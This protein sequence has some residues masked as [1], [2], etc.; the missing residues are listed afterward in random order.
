MDKKSIPQVVC[1]F[2]IRKDLNG[3]FV[4]FFHTKGVLTFNELGAF[5]VEKI[6]G[7]TN[8]SE[9]AKVVSRRYPDV[10]NA[11]NEVMKIVQLLLDA[12]FLK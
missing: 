10:D 5:I 1:R 6:D 4:G 7:Q 3:S 2:K 9:I 11:F 8:I 12:G